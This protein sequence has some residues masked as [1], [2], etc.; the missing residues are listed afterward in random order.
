MNY[1]TTI[2]IY[3]LLTIALEYATKIKKMIRLSKFKK[4]YTKLLFDCH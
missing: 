2:F 4:K 3:F 1:T